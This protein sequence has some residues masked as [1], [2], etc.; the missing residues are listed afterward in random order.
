MLA[1]WPVV[2]EVNHVLLKESE[3]FSRITRELRNRL[4]KTKEK[5][6]HLERNYRYVRKGV[7]SRKKLL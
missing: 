7:I 6:I 4:K 5:V 2:D 3:Y 1:H